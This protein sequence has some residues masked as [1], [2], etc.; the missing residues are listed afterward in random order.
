MELCQFIPLCPLRL[1][2]T[3]RI[4]LRRVRSESNIH[5]PKYELEWRLHTLF[6]S[7]LGTR[8]PSYLPTNSNTR[9]MVYISTFPFFLCRSSHELQT[10]H[11]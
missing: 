1:N 9:T 7:F 11:E 6:V 3:E 5:K 8:T 4:H 10:P 2:N